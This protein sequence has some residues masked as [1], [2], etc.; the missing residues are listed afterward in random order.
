MKFAKIGVYH[1]GCGG[2]KSTE[3]YPSLVIKGTGPFGVFR[4]NNKEILTKVTY[5]VESEDK[6]TLNRFISD[7]KKSNELNEVIILDKKDFSTT[8]STTGKNKT[9]AYE[10]IINSNCSFVS[11]MVM[12]RG[13]ETLSLV[14]KKPEEVIKTIKELEE[15]GEVKVFNIGKFERHENKFKLTKKQLDALNL[16]FV[17]NYYSWPRKVN[18]EKLSEIAGQKRRTFQENL[19]KA[20]CKVF[21]ELLKDLLDNRKYF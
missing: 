1:H 6:E 20:E 21:S 18:I 7:L 8:I 2:S 4:L 3:K 16:A 5:T 12:H 10:T 17:N 15:L 14:S 19:R 11:P 13:Y 9:S